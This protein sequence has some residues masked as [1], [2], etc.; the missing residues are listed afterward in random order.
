[1]DPRF[2]WDDATETLEA[3]ADDLAARVR[4]SLPVKLTKDS[5]GHTVA[6]QPLIKAVQKA[7]DGKVSLVSLPVISDIPIQHGGGGGVTVTHPHKEGDEGVFLFS[8]RSLD[9]WWQQGGEQPQ[10]DARMISHSD[11]FYLPNVRS[12]P[13]KLSNVSTTSTQIR[14]DDGKHFSDWNPTTGTISHSVDGGKHVST[15]SKDGGITHSADNGKHVVSLTDG[16]IS[17]KT[18]MKLAMDA[19][20]GLDVKGPLAVTG[21]ITSTQPIGAGILNGALSGGIGAIV[22][23]L[24]TLGVLAS[25]A[26]SERIQQAR[27][28]INAA[29]S[30]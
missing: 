2:Q 1:M 4:I 9:A 13:R 26:P 23:T 24:I 27:Y 14:S 19:S 28:I 22:G 21:K 5:D 8:H 29:W 6:L 11:G 15:V 18:A 20:K 7:P 30:R 12:T 25:G 17:L 3:L 10:I 16:G